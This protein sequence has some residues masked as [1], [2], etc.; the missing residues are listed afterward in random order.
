MNTNMRFIALILTLIAPNWAAAEKYFDDM[1]FSDVGRI[2]VEL[3]DGAG[4]GCWTNLMEVKTY[5]SNKI[6]LAGGML[7]DKIDDTHGKGV[8]VQI[9]VDATRHPT[10]N[11]C[12]GSISIR[13]LALGSAI[14]LPNAISWVEY[15]NRGYYG[16][17]P[18]NFNTEVLDTVKNA[19]DDW[20]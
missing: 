11:Y 9:N 13:T 16:V 3:S 12:F 2:F 19:L 5:A 17:N 8:V 6:E 7:A 4:G 20:D 15:S 1:K 10:G 18:K 14:H